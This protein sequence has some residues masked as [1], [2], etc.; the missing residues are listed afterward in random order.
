MKKTAFVALL[1]L[2]AP[3]VAQSGQGR[4]PGKGAGVPGAG[5]PAS[6][7]IAGYL[8]TLPKEALSAAETDQLLFLREEEKLA[9]DVYRALFAANGDQSFANIASAEQRHMDE[10]KIL[11]DRYGL[12]D[13]AATTAPGEFRNARLASLYTDLVARGAVSLVE[14]LKVG[15]TVED[16]D[17]ADVDKALDASDNRDIDTVM[18]NLAKGSR[19]HLRAF[20]Q[21]LAAL[22]ATTRPSS[23]RPT[24]S[25]GSSPL[26]AS[27]VRTTRT[28]SSSPAPAP[29]RAGAG[30]AR[31]AVAGAAPGRAPGRARGRGLATARG[32]AARRGSAPGSDP[33]GQGRC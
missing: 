12:A 10:V 19:N 15:A 3:L 2:A 24:R 31:A 6:S 7:P 25:R 32:R 20:S 9:R 33:A 21:R 16:L 18:Q 13:P 17:L 8:A 30:A 22:D 1:L 26:P 4:G 5:P 14:A 27:G 23:S 28:E 11:L 29:G